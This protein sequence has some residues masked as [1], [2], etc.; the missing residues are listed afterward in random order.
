MDEEQQRE[1]F[2]LEND[3]GEFAVARV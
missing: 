3:Y 1:R 2:D